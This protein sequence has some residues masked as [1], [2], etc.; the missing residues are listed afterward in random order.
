MQRKR[1]EVIQSVLD[2]QRRQRCNGTHNPERIRTASKSASA[3]AIARAVELG[4]NDAIE[5]G[6]PPSPRVVSNKD[7]N[8]TSPMD[9]D[10]ASTSLPSL[11]GLSSDSISSTS[12][13]NDDVSWAEKL[14]G[15]DLIPD[16]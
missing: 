5:V 8:E 12:D 6:C 4:I 10:D 9:I 2:E 3:W 11:S 7:N 14:M 13:G 16:L 1:K 15:E